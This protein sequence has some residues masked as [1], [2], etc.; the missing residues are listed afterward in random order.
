MLICLQLRE[1]KIPKLITIPFQASVLR[2]PS[3]HARFSTCMDFTFFCNFLLTFYLQTFLNFLYSLDSKYK[4]L[5]QRIG[6]LQIHD[7]IIG[8]IA[9][10]DIEFPRVW[11]WSK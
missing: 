8:L 1:Q 3:F 4:I 6:S 11:S 9:L 7:A 5:R 2:W 10:M